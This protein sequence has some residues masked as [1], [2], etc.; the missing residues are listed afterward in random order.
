MKLIDSL[1][2][3]IH[4]ILNLPKG[5]PLYTFQGVPNSSMAHG[6][7]PEKTALPFKLPFRVN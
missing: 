2:N 6:F 3:Q 4:S 5:L 1:I 7:S